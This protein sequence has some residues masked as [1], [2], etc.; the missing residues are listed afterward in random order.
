M[1][2]KF[3]KMCIIRQTG[4]NESGRSGYERKVA[5]WEQGLGPAGVE[6]G[7]F[8][9]LATRE[10]TEVRD[11][12]E[13]YGGAKAWAG[14]SGNLAKIALFGKPAGTRAAGLGTSEKLPGGSKG[15]GRR[16]WEMANSGRWQRARQQKFG[17]GARAYGGSKG[18]GRRD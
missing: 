15:L 10:A 17:M 18:L 12:S 3:G 7:Q 1:Q 8:G 2:A 16:E 13:S 4:G 5:G 14:G 11:G 9:A 6:N